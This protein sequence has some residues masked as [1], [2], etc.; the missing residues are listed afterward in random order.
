MK[1]ELWEDE[2]IQIIL[3]FFKEEI[4]YINQ[5]ENLMSAR[6]SSFIIIIDKPDF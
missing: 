1:F 2:G 6:S 4:W 3:H 5:P